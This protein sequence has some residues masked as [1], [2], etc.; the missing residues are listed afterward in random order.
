MPSTFLFIIATLLLSLNFIRP[1]GLAIS[2]WLYFGALGFAF[3]ETFS[4]ERCYAPCWWRNHFLWA[5]ALILFGAII[6]TMNSLNWGI[7]LEE[8]LQQCYVMTVFISLIWIMVRR[9]K[10]APIMW[11]FILSGVFTAGI[12][13]VDY[14]TGSNFGPILSG[15][16]A[17]QFWGRYAGTLGHP[18]KLGYFLVLT[19]LLSLGQLF[20]IKPTR[21]TWLPRLGWD[22][23]I[24]VQAFGIY[25]SGSMTA[26]LG[27]LLGVIALT[28]SSKSIFIRVAK[29]FG[30]VVV[31]GMLI[32]SSIVIFNMF[33]LG[34]PPSLD[35]TSVAQALNRVRTITADSRL[36]IFGQAWSRIIQNPWFGV[37]YDQISTSGLRSTG[38]LVLDVHNSLLQIWYTGGLL[39]FIGWLAIYISVGWMALGVIRNS[40]HNVLSPLILSLA[41][42]TLAILLMDQFQ[43]AIY[44]RE[45]WVVIGLLVGYAWEQ[46]RIEKINQ[47]SIT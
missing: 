44:Q 3:I 26:Y 7:A 11:A 13:L 42:T 38:Q 17:V 6:S 2:D 31:A 27:L 39:A 47:P 34:G 24:A 43:D 29:T 14:L 36:V 33:L 4:L 1:F 35:N 15:T 46:S 45:Q 20:S 41:A 23:L 12:V 8:I 30:A 28:I 19:T 37:G 18:N 32:I 25:I 16:P 22:A 9:G 40:H 21:S 10:I 5:V